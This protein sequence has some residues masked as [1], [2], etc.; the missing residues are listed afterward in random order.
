MPPELAKEGD[1][2][3]ALGDSWVDPEGKMRAFIGT[4][5]EGE[6]FVDYLCIVEIPEDVDIQSSKSGSCIEYPEPPK[7]LNVYKITK[8]N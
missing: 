6:N 8:V 1:F 2:V 3:K 5:K 7:G 4:I